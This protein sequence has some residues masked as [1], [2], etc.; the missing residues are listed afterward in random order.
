MQQNITC[1]TLLKPLKA[2]TIYL[3]DARLREFVVVDV[4]QELGWAHRRIDW[5]SIVNCE[6]RPFY[7]L[8]E[9]I[10]LGE[11][12]FDKVCPLSDIIEVIDPFILSFP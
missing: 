4:C 9:F 1:V 11:K 8:L 5:R 6:E 12:I 7:T 3:F 10:F 2:L